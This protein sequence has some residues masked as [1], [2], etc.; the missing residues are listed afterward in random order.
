MNSDV[1]DQRRVGEH[2]GAPVVERHEEDHEPAADRERRHALAGSNRGRATGRRYAPRRSS[3]APAARRR[4]ARSSGRVH[5]R[6]SKLPA[7]DCSAAGDA[8]LDQRRRID[9]VVEHDRQ[10][11]A[12][13]LRRDLLE[14]VRAARVEARARRGSSP[15]RWCPGAAAHRRSL[16]PSSSVFFSIKYATDR[17]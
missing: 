16:R 5:S 1:D 7:D 12:D 4:A 13:V 11:P 17:L 14:E 10:P 15:V 9:R 8:L 2:A 3:P 6:M